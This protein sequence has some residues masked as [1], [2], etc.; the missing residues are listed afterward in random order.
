MKEDVLEQLVDD[1]LQSLGVFTTQNVHFKPAVVHP[2]FVA[3]KDRVTSDIDVVG[4]SPKRYGA[5]RVWV[6]SCKAWQAGLNPASRLRELRED[7]KRG[8]RQVWQTH[9]ELWSPKWGQALL[10]RVEYLTGQRAFRYF[11]A[12]TRLTGDVS[13]WGEWNEEPQIRHCLEGNP[14]GFLRLEDMWQR[15]VQTSTTTLA[16]SVMGRLAQMLIAADVAKTAVGAT[17]EQ[18]RGLVAPH[19]AAPDQ[20][21]VAAMYMPPPP[22]NDCT[23]ISRWANT[24]DGYK[25]AASRYGCPDG[26]EGLR[27]FVTGRSLQEAWAAGADTA[28]GQ[29]V[30]AERPFDGPFEVLRLLQFYEARA[31][32]HS[33]SLPDDSTLIAEH[34]ALHEAVAQAWAAGRLDRPLDPV[35]G[36]PPVV[37]PGPDL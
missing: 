24:L 15:T 17:A 9:R 8:G 37:E 4:F 36:A 11:T 34:L 5:D 33:G 22:V 30:H 19:E 21:S 23:D 3:T 13:R 26:H 28:G 29:V 16:G 14:V 27:E 12:V 18:D 1:Y 6:V 32:H 31:W 10:D 20:P 2:E 7:K 35:S 25:F